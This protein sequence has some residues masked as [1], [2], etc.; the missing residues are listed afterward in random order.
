MTLVQK[1]FYVCWR[2]FCRFIHKSKKYHTHIQ[3][4]AAVIQAA[5]AFIMVFTLAEGCKALKISQNQFESTVEPY[6]DITFNPLVLTNTITGKLGSNNYFIFDTL[7]SNVTTNQNLEMASRTVAVFKNEGAVDIAN[8]EKVFSI[9]IKFD[10][11]NAIE[12]Q[13]I[14]NTLVSGLLGQS[15]A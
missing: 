3:T 6:I 7:L 15:L 4:I 2:F 8:V 14:D 13:F 9:K 11:Y 1:Q 12:N 10:N 5:L